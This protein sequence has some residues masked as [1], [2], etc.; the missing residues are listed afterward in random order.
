MNPAMIQALMASL[1]ALISMFQGDPR[2]KMMEQIQALMSPQNQGALTNKFYQGQIAS[3]A[4][5]QAQGAIAAGGN[6]AANTIAQNLGAR[7]IGTSGLG[8]ILPGLTS[9]MIGGQQA[10]LRT[11]AYQNAQGQAQQSIQQQINNLLGSQGPSQTQQY[12]S[13]GLGA[14]ANALPGMMGQGKSPQDFSQ[15]LMGRNRLPMNALLAALGQGP[16]M[17]TSRIGG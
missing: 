17:G 6:Q 9:S 10:N 2:K 16:S 3:P 7:G 4:Y 5:S 14:F 12:L 8:A 1:P 13:A 11:G 15:Y